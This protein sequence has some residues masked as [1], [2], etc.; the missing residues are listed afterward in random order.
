[1]PSFTATV[2]LPRSPQE[3]FDYLARPANVALL[4]PAD[5]RLQLIAGPERIHLGAVL[6][7]KARRMGIS[8]SIVNDI[9]VFEEAVQIVEEQRAGPFGRWA[10]THRFQATA[11]GSVL[12]SAV[13]YEPPAGLLGLI[14][15][16]EVIHRD[17]E[18]LFAYRT[19]RLR[20]L[21]G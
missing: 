13:I 10:M 2:E 21:F 9:T 20:E 8:Q 15:N 7:W 5:L 12:T 11:T 4:A 3:V 6:H 17:L 16:A 19:E 18:K 1:M 14:V